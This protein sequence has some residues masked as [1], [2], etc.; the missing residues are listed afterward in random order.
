[1]SPRPRFIAIEGLDGAGT[2]TQ[3]ERLVAW[4]RHLGR[5]VYPTR[6]PSD[7]RVGRLIRELLR[8]DAQPADPSALA[9]LFAAD[10]LAHLADEIRPALARGE[11]VV[12]DRYALSSLAYQGAGGNLDWVRQLNARAD[13]PDVT[14]LLDVP[15]EL[16]LAR[17]AG[18]GG[19]RDI[20]EERAALEAVARS[21][22][23][24]ATA[25]TARPGRLEVVRGD[26]APDEVEADVR[27]IVQ[28]LLANG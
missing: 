2:T 26:R 11:D 20:Y 19:P 14:V 5:R 4:L 23:E 18:R 28:A 1:L 13:E 6:E 12:T 22:R 15:V 7:G 17:L 9:L 8:A 25:A 3:S 21:Y 10:R 16:C 27:A 24:L